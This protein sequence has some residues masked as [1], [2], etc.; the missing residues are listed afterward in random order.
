MID[1]L[2]QNWYYIVFFVLVILICVYGCMTGKVKEWLKW[3]VTEAEAYLGSGTGQLKL[4][5]VYDWFIDQFP[6]F[7]RILPFFIFS[8][9]VDT[10]LEWMREQLEKN[11]SIRAFIEDNVNEKEENK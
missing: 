6:V 4:R 10:A 5:Q 11:L 1:W 9:M 2:M 8:K 3:A 7:S